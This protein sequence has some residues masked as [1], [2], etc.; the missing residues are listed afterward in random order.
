METRQKLDAAL[1]AQCAPITM[2]TAAQ[3]GWYWPQLSCRKSKNTPHSIKCGAGY[4]AKREPKSHRETIA[5]ARGAGRDDLVS[6]A[7][8]EIVVLEEFLPKPLSDEELSALVTQAIAET[9][10]VVPADMGEVSLK[11]C[12]HAWAGAL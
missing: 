3:S 2:F 7:E 6:A 11:H 12:S 5:E 4:P 9:G 8:E 1:K 10:A